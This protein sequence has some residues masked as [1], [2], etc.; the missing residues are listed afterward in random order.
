MPSLTAVWG[1][2][3][4]MGW[5][6]AVPS[7]DLDQ[8]HEAAQTR[9]EPPGSACALTVS[10]DGA[11]KRNLQAFVG[12]LVVRLRSHSNGNPQCKESFLL[13]D[14]GAHHLVFPFGQTFFEI[15]NCTLKM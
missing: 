15:S 5:R 3:R 7:S 2:M 1:Y 8:Q 9:V 13:M 10:V 11:T 6:R 4:E 12:Q 14:F